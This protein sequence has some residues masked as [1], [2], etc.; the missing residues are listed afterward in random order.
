MIGII[1]KNFDPITLSDQVM[2]NETLR[3]GLFTKILLI[4]HKSR[5]WEEL[6]SIRYR[7]N[8]CHLIYDSYP[9]IEIIGWDEGRLYDDMQKL[10]MSYKPWELTLV[11]TEKDF[12]E[13]PGKYMGKD[14]IRDYHFLLYDDSQGK[15]MKGEDFY[16]AYGYT[17]DGED[18]VTFKKLPYIESPRLEDL[19]DMIDNGIDTFPWID[20][21]VSEYIKSNKIGYYKP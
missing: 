11:M 6:A 8:M 1:P 18:Q 3:S 20:P 7:V 5:D 10:G 4:P 16:Q 21:R 14:I 19:H 15:S 12:S 9:E 13:L 2:I 17:T